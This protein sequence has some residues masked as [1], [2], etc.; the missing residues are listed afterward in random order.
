[1]GQF[2]NS[3]AASANA[4][5]Q[6]VQARTQGL[7]DRKVAYARAYGLER[8]SAEQ[9]Y[10]AAQQMQTMRQNQTA[11]TASTRLDNA[12]SGFAASSGS[13]L[14][15]EMSTAQIFEEVIAHAGKSYAITDQNARSQAFQLRKEGDDALKMSD[16]MANYYSRVSK[17]NS[18]AANWHLLGG[19]ASTIGDTMFTYNIGGAADQIKNLFATK[20]T[21]TKAT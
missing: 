18:T 20:T 10:I 5:Q 19:T 8:D 9:G 2:V 7:A 21:P 4:A 3:S 1:M 15:H 13:K 17:I 11:A 12:S 16:I 14:R 6:S